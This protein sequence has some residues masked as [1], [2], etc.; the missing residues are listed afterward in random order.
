[1]AFV[2]YFVLCGFGSFIAAWFMGRT[3]WRD[4]QKVSA[5]VVSSL[6]TTLGLFCLGAAWTWWGG[7]LF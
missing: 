4:E 2:V 6:T 3:L 1:M 5:V 7:V